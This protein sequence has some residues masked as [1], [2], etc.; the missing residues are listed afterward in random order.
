M[1]PGMQTRQVGPG[2]IRVGD[3]I[4]GRPARTVLD[5]R[6]LASGDRRLTLSDGT[7]HTLTVGDQLTIVRKT[8]Q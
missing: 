4:L 6:R 3:T 8:G 2:T 7:T 1:T 5:M